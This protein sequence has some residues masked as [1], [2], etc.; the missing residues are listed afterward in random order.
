MKF[1]RRSLSNIELMSAEADKE[2]KYEC[3][4][5]QDLIPLVKDGIA[6]EKSG[7]AVMQHIKECL[8]CRKAY[9]TDPQIVLPPLRE[10]ESME[11]SKVTLYKN[12]IKKRRRIMISLAA[13]LAVAL[14]IGTSLI[15][16][17]IAKQ[18][19]IGDSYTTRDIAK[20]GEYSGHIEFEQEGFFSLLEIFPK[21][22]PP[23]ATVEDYYYFCSNGG[24]FDNSYQLYLV[25]SYEKDD[26]VREK[27]RLESLELT[28]RDEVHK[29]TITDTGFKYR[30]VVT[31]F[32][33]QNSFEYALIDDETRTIAYV[34]AQS[35]GIKESVVPLQY[36]PQGF[37]LPQNALT[38]R[39]SY[40]IYYFK[41]HEGAYVIPGIDNIK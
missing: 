8:V 32:N 2:Y 34:F 13:L 37:K 28:F 27:E 21:E 26:F 18:I 24:L 11:M 1:E 19:I 22:L 20:Y 30:A 35:M 12:R 17:K 3:E 25:C 4:I 23:S 14:V 36:R 38:E 16:V 31:I 41:L 39:G 6:S 15:T 9:E 40:N 5:I 29:P 10:S 33:D 7:A